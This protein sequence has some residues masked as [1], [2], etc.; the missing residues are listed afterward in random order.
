MYYSSNIIIIHRKHIFTTPLHYYYYIMLNYIIFVSVIKC[1]DKLED[2]ILNQRVFNILLLMW[3][4][5]VSRGV[6]KTL[7]K[8]KQKIPSVHRNE[9]VSKSNNV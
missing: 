8:A 9:L 6:L 4:M 1:K 7:D 2:M 5:I 3:M